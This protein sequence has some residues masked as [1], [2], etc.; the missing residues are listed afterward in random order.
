MGVKTVAIIGANG[1]VGSEVI[2]HLSGNP[3]IRVVPICRNAVGAAFLSHCGIECRVGNIRNGLECRELLRGVD[4][5]ADFTLPVGGASEVKA[6]MKGIIESVMENAQEGAPYVYLSS[7]TAF[8]FP[9][10]RAPLR[11]YRISQNQYGTLK[12]YA[13]AL[14][15]RHAG[16]TR[17]KA[18]IYRVGVVHGELQAVSRKIMEDI[19]NSEG[20]TAFVPDAPSYTVFAYSIAESIVGALTEPSGTYT[21]V[22]NPAWSWQDVYHYYARHLLIQ[23]QVEVVPQTDRRAGQWRRAWDVVSEPVVR[24]S[25][26]HRGAIGTY[27]AS[28]SKPLESQ[29]RAAYLRR[30]AL[31]ELTNEVEAGRW[32]PF[33]MNFDTLPGK[34]LPCLT[35]SRITMEESGRKVRDLVAEAKQTRQ[36]SLH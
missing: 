7:I 11:Y 18:I 1:Q 19:R 21:L 35:D 33:G 30:M 17:R 22:S 6:S 16:R 24:W 31:H 15:E 5:V 28:R 34:R 13:E 26:A 10:F 3:N 27:L 2:L 32:Q 9:D 25:V 20:V 23:P 29:L 4:V 36:K 8:G 14:V 12:R